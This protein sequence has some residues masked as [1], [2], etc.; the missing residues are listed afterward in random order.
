[1]GADADLGLDDWS[2]LLAQVVTP[3]G[4]VDYERLAECRNLL[5]RFVERL[6]A[7]G[8]GNR[9][10]LFPTDDHR[11]AYW[12][13]AYNAFTLHAIIAE[14]PINSVWKTRDGQFFQRRRH[15]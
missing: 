2:T 15:L 6:G 4:K 11:L 14:Y 13:N 1:M 3:E 10:E 12:L 8:P 7:I 5:D 9:P